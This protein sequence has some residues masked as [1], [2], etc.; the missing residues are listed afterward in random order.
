[1]QCLT[2]I[3]P[4]LRGFV[5]KNLDFYTD[6]E[7]TNSPYTVD[8]KNVSLCGFTIRLQ[9]K[10]QAHFTECIIPSGLLVSISWVKIGNLQKKSNGSSV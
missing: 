6:F 1:M 8:G 7:I 3:G 2:S 9:R 4:E 10:F 5:E